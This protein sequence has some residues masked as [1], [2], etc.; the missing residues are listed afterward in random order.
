[1]AQ[2]TRV[3]ELLKK[4]NVKGVLVFAGGIIPDEDARKLKKLG[5]QEV[6]GPGSSIASIAEFLKKRVRPR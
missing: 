3:M 1:M 5:I 4:E 6:F 2:F